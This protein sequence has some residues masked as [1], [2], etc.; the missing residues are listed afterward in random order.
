MENRPHSADVSLH[1]SVR[2]PAVLT[3]LRILV[4]EDE[5]PLREIL[6]E[7]LRDE[8]FE[9][10]TAANGVEA[11]ELYTSSGPFDVLLLDD[12]MPRLTGRRLLVRLREDG[13]RVPVILFSGN[14]E[15][16]REEQARLNVGPTLRKP[17]SLDDLAG[18]IRRVV[19][20]RP[21]PV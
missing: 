12:E 19:R 6:A 9:V 1:P 7:G 4:A 15:M 8:G 16:S 5:A 17:V 2:E 11:L 18:A 21:D 20:D 14:L 13:E 10:V 3:R